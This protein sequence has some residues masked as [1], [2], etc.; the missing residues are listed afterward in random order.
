[1]TDEAKS[2]TLAIGDLLCRCLEL[3]PDNLKRTLGEQTPALDRLKGAF[4]PLSFEGKVA[5]L[6]HRACIL[7]NPGPALTPW[8]VGPPPKQLSPLEELLALDPATLGDPAFTADFSE[9]Q[10][11][12]I[13]ASDED[14][15]PSD[16]R[17]FVELR[18]RMEELRRIA[19]GSPPAEVFTKA[20]GLIANVARTG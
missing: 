13:A 1:M 12:L 11:R 18:P 19:A 10:K 4:D 9:F 14:A 8:D 17:K 20:L 15:K 6:L 7:V 16:R 3:R 5:G 2:E